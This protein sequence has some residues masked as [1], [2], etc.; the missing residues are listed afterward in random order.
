MGD[1]KGLKTDMGCDKNIF[2][3]SSE[4]IDFL[5]DLK[6]RIHTSQMRAALAAN[7]ELISLYWHIGKS[8]VRLQKEKDGE[9][10]S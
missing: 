3:H 6:N 7:S 2:P 5:S 10:L 1:K 8:I 9:A 4:Y